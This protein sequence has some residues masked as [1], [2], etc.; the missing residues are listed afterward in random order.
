MLYLG[1]QSHLVPRLN[2]SSSFILFSQGCNSSPSAE[3]VTVCPWLSY[4]GGPKMDMAFQVQSKK[5]S[6]ECMIPSHR[7]WPCPRWCSLEA[8]GHLCFQG[9]AGCPPGPG[10]VPWS[11]SPG[12]RAP[13]LCWQGLCLPR[14]GLHHRTSLIWKPAIQHS[15]EILERVKLVLLSNLNTLMYI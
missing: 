3:L 5:P 2:K 8:V 13:H 6:A 12:R 9:S 15:K 11:C 7:L 1:P 4:S 14:A 10:A